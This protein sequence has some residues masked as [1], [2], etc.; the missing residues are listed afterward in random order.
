MRVPRLR[1]GTKRREEKNLYTEVASGKSKTVLV[2]YDTS[3]FLATP[4]QMEYF[5]I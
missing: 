1:R 4:F 3:L 5:R 2:L